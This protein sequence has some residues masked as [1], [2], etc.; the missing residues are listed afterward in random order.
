MCCATSGD[1][2][3]VLALL[4]VEVMPNAEPEARTECDSVKAPNGQSRSGVHHE[5]SMACLIS[6][7]AAHARSN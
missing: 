7:Q 5:I 2:V 4:P 6:T 1:V 3:L